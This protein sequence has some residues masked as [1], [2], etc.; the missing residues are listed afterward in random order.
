MGVSGKTWGAALR[1]TDAA[2]N[3]I[4]VSVGHRVSL[5]TSLTVVKACTQKF[6]IP[7]PIRQAD[8]RSRAKVKQIYGD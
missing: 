4:I 7:E 3:P 1:A 2:K 5:S 6:K 8:L